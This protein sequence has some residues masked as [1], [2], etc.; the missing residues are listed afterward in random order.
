MLKVTELRTDTFKPQWS[1]PKLL[2]GIQCDKVC[3]CLVDRLFLFVS[4]WD[5]TAQPYNIL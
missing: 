3:F 2:S 4:H 1:S 5:H